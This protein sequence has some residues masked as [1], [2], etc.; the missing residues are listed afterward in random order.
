MNREREIK[1]IKEI[2]GRGTMLTIKMTM[3][4]TKTDYRIQ[5]GLERRGEWRL[6][7]NLHDRNLQ[8]KFP[9]IV[10]VDTIDTNHLQRK[11]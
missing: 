1:S 9:Q 3:M 7:T 6:N 10:A 11:L 4:I 2:Q 8:M 5:R